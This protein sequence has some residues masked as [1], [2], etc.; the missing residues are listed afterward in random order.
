MDFAPDPDH[1]A[2]R[3]GV[4]RVCADFDDAYW[5]RC[6]SEHE[7]P[8]DFYRAMADGGWRMDRHCHSC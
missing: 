5:R 3:E 8:W 7:F 6:D 4:R 1:Q 2:I